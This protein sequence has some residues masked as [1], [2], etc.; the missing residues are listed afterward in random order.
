MANILTNPAVVLLYWLAFYYTSW[1]KILVMI[2][3]ELVAILVE[4]WYYKKYGEGFKRPFLF[5]VTANVISFTAGLLLQ[6]IL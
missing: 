4:W 6:L 5:S 2:A 1:N 3:L